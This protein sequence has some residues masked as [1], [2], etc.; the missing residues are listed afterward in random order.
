MNTYVIENI[1]LKSKTTKSVSTQSGKGFIYSI[2]LIFL[3][4]LLWFLKN[5][6]DV[7]LVEHSYYTTL[8]QYNTLN[9]EVVYPNRGYIYTKDNVKLAENRLSYNIYLT[10]PV[11]IEILL[12]EVPQLEKYKNQIKKRLEE[13]DKTQTPILLLQGIDKNE[14]ILI[15]KNE[16]ITVRKEF[17]R[18]YPTSEITAHLVGYIGPVSKEDLKSDQTLT[19]TDRTGKNGLEKQYDP[20]LRGKKGFIFVERNALGEEIVRYQYNS[21]SPIDGANLYTTIEYRLQKA[22]FESLR[23]VVEKYKIKAGSAVILNPY[24]GEV[25]A[26]VSYPSYDNNAFVDPKRIQE[27]ANYLKDERLP[28]FNRVIQAQLPPGSTFKTIVSAAA[29]E[30][31]IIDPSTRLNS[32]GYIVLSGGLKF[33]NF[34]QRSHGFINVKEAL[35]VSSNV[36]FCKVMLK[37]GI[38]T[39]IP[40]AQKFGIGTKTGIDLPYENSGR[41]ATPEKKIELAQTTSPWLDPIWYPEG[42]S[43]NTAIG[44][45]ITLVTPIQ[46]AK[47]ASVFANG[48]YIITP[49]LAAYFEYPDGTIVRP[50][51]PKKQGPI[52]NQST[53]KTVQQGMRL[54]VAGDRALLRILNNAPV[55]VAAKSG[56]AEFGVKKEYGYDNTHGWVMGFYP[57]ENPQYAFAVLLENG[58]SGWKA[59]EVI[60][61]FLKKTQE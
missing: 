45:G 39:F 47:I 44:Q 23:E 17:I 54:A 56:T 33:Q 13:V 34:R 16:Y 58:G 12:K 57:Y 38:R 37:M 19:Y 30:E 3:A 42:D 31:K 41:L 51:F 36:F 10:K 6:I 21:Q 29:L 32:P 46:L 24:N 53:V 27:V 22:L 40:Y 48:G 50:E 61:R 5:H 52:L 11:S 1:P 14:A 28:L 7:S 49:H 35:M 8:A 59:A 2:F 4:I 26:L 15:P 20:I 25:L 9:K 60:Y 43:C 18:A 55:K